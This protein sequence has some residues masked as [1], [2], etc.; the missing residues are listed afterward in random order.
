MDIVETF[1]SPTLRNL[2]GSLPKTIRRSLC[3]AT[4]KNIPPKAL[5]W[6]AE[7]AKSK[8]TVV[9]KG[10]SHVAMVSHPNIVAGL[11]EKTAKTA[12]N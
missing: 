12:S 10:R 5:K 2:P 9:V 11:T 1:S 6:M 7:R 8:D 3:T 4:H